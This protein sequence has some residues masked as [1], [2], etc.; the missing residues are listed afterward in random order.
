MA[1]Y[2]QRIKE[3]DF[4]FEPPVIQFSHPGGF[5]E[6]GFEL[7]LTC[8]QAG[9][10]VYYTLDGSEPDRLRVSPD[11]PTHL[12]S[13]PVAVSSRA[14]SPNILS[15]ISE[16][17]PQWA[18]PGGE[19]FKGTVI[20]ARAYCGPDAPGEPLYPSE[21]GTNTYFVD[22][23]MPERYSLPLI[24]VST[25]PDGLFHYEEGIYVMGRIYYDNYD[26]ALSWGFRPANY[27]Q[28]GYDWE[29]PGNIEF[30][31]AD[32]TPG[33][34]QGVGLRIHGGF[35]RAFRQKSLRIYARR[36]YDAESSIEYEVFPGLR[37]SQGAAL[38]SFS[39]L[40]LRNSG[41]DWSVTMFRV[42]CS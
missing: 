36:E 24:S 18:P 23:G 37:D 20:R 11:G 25:G 21:T 6:E 3:K 38:N 22:Q 7:A 19:V 34:N 29:R 15:E 8:S 40:I 12:Y 33:F 30:Y 14:G 27:H 1:A 16:T 42:A 26:P 39:R 4:D 32:G 28:S 31:E 10:P 5:Y 9:L 41:N 2:Y 35:T 13:G 17:S